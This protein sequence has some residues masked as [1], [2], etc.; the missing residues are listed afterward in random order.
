V[1]RYLPQPADVLTVRTGGWAARLIRLGE[2]MQGKN[3]LDNHVVLVHH[4]DAQGRLWGLE[5]KPGGV[6]WC[7]LDAYLNDGMTVNNCLQPGRTPAGRKAVC[8]A[9]MAMLGTP[10]DWDAIADDTLRA[11]RL[12]DIWSRDWRGKAPGHVVCSSYAAFLYEREGWARPH[13]ADRDTEPGDWAD[14]A[15]AN[16][17]S[18]PLLGS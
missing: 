5:G 6:G 9:A 3:S 10:Y 13:V 11:F 12:P 4:E 17:W 2:A 14:F 16:R 15:L 1:T 7:T 18:A 8:A